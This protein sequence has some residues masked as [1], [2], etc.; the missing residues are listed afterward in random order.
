[1]HSLELWRN[2]VCG[3][4]TGSP[5]R[6]VSLHL[7]RSGSQL[8]H[9]IRR[10][11]P[12]RGAC[13]IINYAIQYI[14][15]IRWFS[16][17]YVRIFCELRSKNASNEQN[18]RSYYM[19]NHRI[20]GLLFHYKKNVILQLATIFLVRVLRNTLIPSVKMTLTMNKIFAGIICQTIEREVDYSTA[21]K[22]N[23]ASIFYSQ[24]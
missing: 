14:H 22:I 8:E 24:N 18:V 19:L 2:F 20:R 9:R 15:L 6:A 3:N 10:I 13:H 4:K 21:K 17:K 23:L 16:I 7:A 11:L 1:M 12:A 5:G